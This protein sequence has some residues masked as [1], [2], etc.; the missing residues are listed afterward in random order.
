M[1]RF[2]V[3]LAFA[4]IVLLICTLALT[5]GADV[6]AQSPQATSTPVLESGQPGYTSYSGYYRMRC[7]PACHTRDIPES[8]Q[9]RQAHHYTS[10]SGYYRMRCWPGCHT[11]DIPESIQPRQPRGYT[12]YSGYYRMR[13]WPGCH[14][15]DIPESITNAH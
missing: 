8:I 11:R 12:S 2:L 7:W 13:C 1:R 6:A 4:G 14:T 3:L 10:Y 9:P 5:V 15:K